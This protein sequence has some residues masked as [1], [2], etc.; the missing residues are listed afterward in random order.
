[1]CGIVGSVN[2]SI[3]TS[4]VDQ[5][6]GH[7]GPD[8]KNLY[9][10]NGVELYHLRLSIQDI[11]GGTQPMEY[12]DRY[13]LIYN[14]EI[15]NHQELRTRHNLNCLT[16]SDTETLLY[17]FH[18]FGV[19]C[20]QMLDGMF[21][22]ALLDKKENKIILG[23]DRAGKKPL[24][25]FQDG[26]KTVFA[27][28]LNCLNALLPLQR[29]DKNIAQ[30]IRFGYF[31]QENTPY[32]KIRELAA[33]SYAII[34]VKSQQ[35]TFHKWWNIVDFYKETN[36]DNFEQSL[37]KVDAYLKLA[38]KRRYDAS[39]L[40]VGTF[41][42]GGIDSGLV[43]AIAAQHSGG[44]ALKTFTVSFDGAYN[45]AD[46]ARLVANK[47]S[48]DH[49]EINISFT[50]LKNDIEKILGNYGEPFA[51]SSAIPSYYV[52]QEAKKHLTVILNGD[53]ADE[54]FG[55]YR[56]YVPF[57]SIDFFK[58]NHIRNFFSRGMLKLL[59]TSN[60]KRS[61]YSFLYRLLS[62]SSKNGLS[63]Y[64][65]ATTDIFEDFENYIY[66]PQDKFET[67]KEDYEQIFT[68]KLSG[69]NK[70]MLSDFQSLLFGDLLVK[71][72]I[73]TMSNSLEGRSPFL[74]K[75]LLEYAPSL[76][77]SFKIKGKTTKVLLRKLSKRYLPNEIVHQPK[78]GFE[79]PLKDWIENDLK[80]L[81]FDALT[82]SNALSKKFVK[83][84]FINQLLLKK[85]H[86]SAEKRARMLW[87]LFS[88]EV[89][90]HNK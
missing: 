72:D 25:L 67:I 53:G 46:L 37:N 36:K 30:Y 11:T 26:K 29:N 74:S 64:L 54:L 27:S 65:S 24:Y 69:L 17:L 68:S 59:P 48:T 16:S 33:G 79:I 28:E 77:D 85:I 83:E 50:N 52:S 44:K 63:C 18:L 89:W 41:L 86:V 81:I 51:D 21:A 6:M 9:Q 66:Q 88:L 38:I 40:E 87:S 62:L 71:M 78:R 14:G 13:V 31:Y 82:S 19:N 42:S 56:R 7:R 90:N 55:G 58:T 32:E 5:V 8:E 49:T 3:N 84:E 43:T 39:D 15:Y 76:N 75:E 47:Y 57:K 60:H 35:T 4:T 70:L 45:E 80:D 22:F 1:M 61:Y 23:R 10:E 12:L 2:L 34:D 73:A 20:L